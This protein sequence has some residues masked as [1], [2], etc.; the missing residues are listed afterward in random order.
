M[1]ALEVE[2]KFECLERAKDKLKV[3]DR[4]YRRQVGKVDVEKWVLP[5]CRMAFLTPGHTEHV[6][7]KAI[8]KF[9]SVLRGIPAEHAAGVQ[10]VSLEGQEELGAILLSEAYMPSRNTVS[11]HAMLCVCFVR[12]YFDC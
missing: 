12:N 9:A 7:H 8:M 1:A 4:F 11:T 10:L 5:A 2:V 6:V 3:I